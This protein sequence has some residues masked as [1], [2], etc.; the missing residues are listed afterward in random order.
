MEQLY[1]AIQS[2]LIYSLHETSHPKEIDSGLK[3]MIKDSAVQRFIDLS[4]KKLTSDLSK[5]EDKAFNSLFEDPKVK[6]YLEAAKAVGRRNGWLHGVPTGMVVGAG[7]GMAVGTLT[8]G[9]ILVAALALLGAALGGVSIGYLFSKV[10]EIL[11]KWT[12]EENLTN[13]KSLPVFHM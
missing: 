8:G 1:K 12:A 4:K 5:E 13:S 2:G 9:G 7:A 10:N 6:A 11:N 3:D